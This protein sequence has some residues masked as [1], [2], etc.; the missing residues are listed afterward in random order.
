MGGPEYLLAVSVLGPL[1]AY[2]PAPGVELIPYFLALLACAG[3]ALMSVF[4]S[5]INAFL[6]WL[7]RGRR[8]GPA[9]APM[10]PKTA[11]KQ[12]GEGPHNRA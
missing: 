4:L 10:D 8:A 9:G 1:L 7:R 3:M 12:E 2:G 5:P 6:R 11:P